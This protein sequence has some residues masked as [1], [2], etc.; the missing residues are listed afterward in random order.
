MG[1]SRSPV[2]SVLYAAQRPIPPLKGAGERGGSLDDF[3]FFYDT[4][5]HLTY[6]LR[7]CL[8]EDIAFFYTSIVTLFQ[9]YMTWQLF[10]EELQLMVATQ[11]LEDLRV[12]VDLRISV[13]P[14]RSPN[15]LNV[16]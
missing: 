16:L 7:R 2:P 8:D 15:Y 9:L 5:S 10:V 6:G 13:P 1:S 4:N 12:P 3:C 14:G 11:I